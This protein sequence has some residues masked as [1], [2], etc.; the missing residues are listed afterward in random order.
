[1]TSMRAGRSHGLVAAIGMMG[2]FTL[3]FA[4]RQA[5]AADMLWDNANGGLFSTA[6]NW[7][8]GVPGPNDVARFGTTDSSFFQRTYRVG[9]TSNP[10][11]QQLVVE[12]DGVTFNL[13]DHTYE[14]KNTFVSAALGTVP[15]R[16]GNLTVMNGTLRLPNEADLE[17]ASVADG[18]G[19]LTVGAGALV[20]G[21]SD[22][23][24]PDVRVGLNGN[25]TLEINNGGSVLAQT[26]T[27]GVNSGSTGTVTVTGNG[28]SLYI[29]RGLS[30]SGAGSGTL[31]IE[32][33]GSVDVGSLE[34][35][36][37]GALHLEGGTLSVGILSPHGQRPF[38]WTSGT[39]TFGTFFDDLTIPNGGVLKSG[40]KL[41]SLGNI[42]E[43]SSNV[44]GN[45]TLLPGATTNVFS[46][47]LIP[48][49]PKEIKGFSKIEVDGH[50]TLEGGN[51]Q[52]SLH[53]PLA[54]PISILEDKYEIITTGAGISGSFANVANG[55]RLAA[56]R[57]S[58]LVNYGPGSP[59]DPK[60]VV[61]SSFQFEMHGD[62]DGDFDVDGNDFLV[63]QRGGSPTPLS[64]TD[65]AA[66]R[67]NYGRRGAVAAAASVAVPEP[68]TPWL[69][70]AWLA[71]LPQLRRIHSQ[72]AR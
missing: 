34:F 6:T 36:G 20:K 23:S 24:G 33:G 70:L 51:L 65:L 60:S 18:E 15:N 39:L 57:G 25:G 47:G 26:M 45:L 35:G 29:R 3:P 5:L 16:S 54:F 43:V 30:L 61:L 69:A 22:F 72:C 55:Q 31:R 21:G 27:I 62:F 9:F 68:M 28:S 14:L 52:L 50:V 59:F 10:I 40:G 1:M 11:N 64:A 37:S 44:G 71:I 7:F 38:I 48:N 63:W 12:D 53:D 4:A 56:T 67:T 17:I 46:F 8:P 66:W 13:S 42:S 32:T 19:A 41:D 49:S 2:L 58:F